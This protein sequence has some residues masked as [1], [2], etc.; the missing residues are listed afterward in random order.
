MGCQKMSIV[1]NGLPKTRVIAKKFIVIENGSA[2]TGSYGKAVNKN[3]TPAPEKF[4]FPKQFFFKKLLSTI[5]EWVNKSKYPILIDFE[6]FLF[7][8]G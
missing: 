8:L 7:D 1:Q 4:F 6:F 3:G 2:Q 5:S